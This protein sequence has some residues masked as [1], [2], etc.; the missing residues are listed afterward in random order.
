[1]TPELT[2][3]TLAALL[4][5]VQFALYA[6]PPTSSSARKTMSPATQPI[7]LDRHR[8]PPAP[9]HEQPLRRADPVHHRRARHPLSANT[10][11]HRDLRV[12]LSG[13]RVSTFPPMLWPAPVAHAHLA[14]RASRHAMLIA[15]SLTLILT[16][17][18]VCHS[19]TQAHPF[20]QGDSHV[21]L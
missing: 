18:T 1:M 21:Q 6:V 8:R 11:L 15:A 16:R 19:C 4:Q 5:V 13:A 3:L 10:P 17:C 2:V 20:D 9:R 12:G 7:E 14:R